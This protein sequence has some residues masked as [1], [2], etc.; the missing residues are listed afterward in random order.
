MTAFTPGS[1]VPKQNAVSFCKC[2]HWTQNESL[3]ITWKLGEDRFNNF[4]V[5]EGSLWNFCINW[6]KNEAKI[7]IFDRISQ[8]LLD[9]FL[10][11]WVVISQFWFQHVNWHSEILWYQYKWP[12]SLS[13]KKLY[14]QCWKFYWGDQLRSLGEAATYCREIDIQKFGGISIN[15]PRV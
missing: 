4:G 13:C 2:T 5:W 6:T 14:R 1:A 11:K 12:Q 3:Y 9:W 10:P 15:G 7:S 8:Q